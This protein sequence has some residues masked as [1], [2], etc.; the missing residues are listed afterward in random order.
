MSL[1]T[2]NEFITAAV[3]EIGTKESPAGSNRVKY[4]LWYKLIGAWC[5]MFISWLGYMTGG[6]SIIGRFAS[7]RSHAAWFQRRGQWG[8]QAK[9]GA[10]VFYDFGVGH[11]NHVGL[12]EKV[13]DGRRIQ[14]IEGNTSSGVIGSQSNGGGVYRRIRSTNSVVGYGYPAYAAPKKATVKLAASGSKKVQEWQT[15]LKFAPY[16]R[17]GIWGP[18][19]DQ[20]SEWMATAARNV[21]GTLSGSKK[22]TI[23]LIQRIVGTPDDGDWGPKSRA[24]M[25]AWVKRA[26]KF[27]GVTADGDWGKKTQ[28]AYEKFRKSNS[29]V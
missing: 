26:Q 25:R 1:P 6:Q 16:R 20:R 11:I 18:D 24:K 4:S 2:V 17:D 21:S 5:D 19:T 15:L 13:V 22:S 28:A 9:P 8:H 7:T 14:T 12:V 3:K 23:Q 10:I 29:R 27:L